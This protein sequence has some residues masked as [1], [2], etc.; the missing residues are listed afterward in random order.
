LLK[1]NKMQKLPD[2]YALTIKP[3]E[4]LKMGLS[5]CGAYSVKAI[6]SAYGK[7]TK[8]HPKEYHPGLLGRIT[9]ATLN[10]EYWVRVLNS[11]GIKAEAKTAKELTDNKKLET[12]KKILADNRPVMIAIANG[13]DSQGRYIPVRRFFVGHWITLWGYEDKK[14]I[15]YVYDSCVPKERYDKTI[16]IGNTKRTYKQ[17]LRD[18]KG[19]LLSMIILRGFEK[20]HYIEVTLNTPGG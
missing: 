4:Y 20:Y 17:I 14:Q 7:D 11:H 8:G 19:S 6:L 12:L 18:W 1:L 5:H 9:G 2:K 15:F 10:R 13:Y 16:P 3:E